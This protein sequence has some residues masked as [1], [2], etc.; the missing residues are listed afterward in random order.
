VNDRRTFVRLLHRLPL[1]AHGF[2]PFIRNDLRLKT[3]HRSHS[4]RLAKLYTLP[5]W[6]FQAEFDFASGS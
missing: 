6:A 4:L 3:N 1:V 2:C 5:S